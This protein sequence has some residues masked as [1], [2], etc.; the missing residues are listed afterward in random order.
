MRKRILGL[1]AAATMVV[2]GASVPVA[3]HP[4]P[5]HGH[6]DYGLC[7]AFANGSDQKNQ[8]PPFEDVDEDFCEDVTRPSG[9]PNGNG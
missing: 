3:A 4:G 6:N 1:L 2:G 8:A 9:P 7:T 5:H